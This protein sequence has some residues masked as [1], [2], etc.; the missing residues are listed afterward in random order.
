LIKNDIEYFTHQLRSEKLFRVVIRGLHP[1]TETDIITEELTAQGH[2][3]TRITNVTVKKATETDSRNKIS[4]P[5]PLFY[6]DL[7]T[8]PNN[9]EVYSIRF[10]NH[11]RVRIEPPHE[12]REIIPQCLR[13][14]QLGHTKNFCAQKERCVKCAGSHP[15]NKC[16]FPKERKPK[17]ANCLGEH[18][19]NYRGCPAYTA[20]Y[21]R[22]FPKQVKAVDRL[23]DSKGTGKMVPADSASSSN[24][25]ANRRTT[26]DDE[27]LT[28][29]QRTA[30]NHSKPLTPDSDLQKQIEKIATNL[31]VLAS[32]FDS[33]HSDIT[34][35]LDK[36]EKVNQKS[37]TKA[38][39]TPVKTLS[40][41]ALRKKSK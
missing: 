34:S 8:Q 29:N 25:A 13:C 27:S 11:Q 32:N 41:L 40:Q 16:P 18:T 39:A 7:K 22:R 35:R 21:E 23:R 31:A 5:A 28:S 4:V 14:Q 15:S 3:A 24:N 38:T 12:K 6:V 37:S 1:K 19:A 10:I 17:C 2:T 36:I 26:P 9:N 33:F 20:A 30:H